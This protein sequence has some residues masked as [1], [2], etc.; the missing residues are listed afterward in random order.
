MLT[1]VWY[2]DSASAPAAVGD[3]LVLSF[4]LSNDAVQVQAAVVVHGQDHGRVAD[5][6]LHLTQFLQSQLTQCHHAIKKES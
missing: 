1:L 4:D 3:L 6:R 2:Q 5:P